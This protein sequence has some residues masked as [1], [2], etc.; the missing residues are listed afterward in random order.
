MKRARL[1]AGVAIGRDGRDD[2]R[3]AGPREP[4]GDPADAQ[5][6]A[7]AVLLGEAE[8][9]GEV[10]ADDVAVEDLDERAAPLQLVRDEAADGGLAGCGEA[11]QPHGEAVALG[12]A[13]SSWTRAATSSEATVWMPH[14]V[15]SSVAQRPER[16]GPGSVECVSPIDS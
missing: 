15:L 10:R 3:R 7:V 5:D 2:D 12:H 1:T 9:L 13:C 6:V 11:R 14:S 4:R 16:P 8:A